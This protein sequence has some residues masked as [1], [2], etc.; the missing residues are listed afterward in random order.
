MITHMDM[1]ERVL[2]TMKAEESPAGT[3]GVSVR[4]AGLQVPISEGNGLVVVEAPGVPASLCLSQGDGE[5]K[6]TLLW[7][8]WLY[9]CG[10]YRCACFEHCGQVPYN[11]PAWRTVMTLKFGPSWIIWRTPCVRCLHPLELPSL[12]SWHL[13]PLVKPVLQVLLKDVQVLQD[14]NP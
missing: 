11:H 7:R 8:K 5:V 9:A 14:E 2:Y 13:A 12:P 10:S 4:W 3:Q 6:L 1:S